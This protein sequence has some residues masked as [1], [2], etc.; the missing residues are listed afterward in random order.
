MRVSTASGLLAKTVANWT[1]LYSPAG[2]PGSELA[3]DTL[4]SEREATAPSCCRRGWTVAVQPASVTCALNKL[5][6]AFQLSPQ[7]CPSISFAH[8][9]AACAPAWSDALDD[10]ETAIGAIGGRVLPSS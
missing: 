9:S 4:L 1:I 3:L 8:S 10:A 5:P 2:A 6:D 7:R